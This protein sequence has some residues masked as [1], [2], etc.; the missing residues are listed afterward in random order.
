M[1]EVVPSHSPRTFAQS[2][3]VYRGNNRYSLGD[4]IERKR[5]R[6]KVDDFQRFPHLAS[7]SDLPAAKPSAKL[8]PSRSSHPGLGVAAPSTA[9]RRPLDRRL[10]SGSSVGGSG[11]EDPGARRRQR[12]KNM[13]LWASTLPEPTFSL[14]G[15]YQPGYTY[16]NHGASSKRTEDDFRSKPERKR[17][18]T[19]APFRDKMNPFR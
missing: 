18:E 1:K 7:S 2:M 10:V 19:G 12:D 13:V 3:D 17:G 9:N 4:E 11:T 15:S 8:N 16:I 14:P 5:I 6:E